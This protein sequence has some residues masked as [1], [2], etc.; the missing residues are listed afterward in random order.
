MAVF[1]VGGLTVATS[2]RFSMQI[3]RLGDEQFA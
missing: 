3:T 2:L 1:K